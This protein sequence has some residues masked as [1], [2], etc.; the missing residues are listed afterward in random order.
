MGKP[1]QLSEVAR[2]YT[3]IVFAVTVIYFVIMVFVFGSV[4]TSQPTCAEMMTAGFGLVLAALAYRMTSFT[5]ACDQYVRDGGI[6]A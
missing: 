2:G 5:L 6:A 3:L 4:L 1:E